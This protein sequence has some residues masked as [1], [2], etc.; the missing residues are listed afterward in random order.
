MMGLPDG[1][2]SFRI[3]LVVLIQYRLWQTA[4]QPPNHV[5]VAITLNAKASS[6]KN[7]SVWM[8]EDYAAR[9]SAGIYLTD[10]RACDIPGT[11]VVLGCRSWSR[12]P[13]SS[14]APSWTSGRRVATPPWRRTILYRSAARHN[15]KAAYYRI[16][17]RNVRIS[18]AVND[19]RHIRYDYVTDRFIPV[20][21]ILVLVLA[22]PVLSYPVQRYFSTLNISECP[23]SY[24]LRRH[25]SLTRIKLTQQS[26][27]C[28]YLYVSYWMSSEPG[29]RQCRCGSTTLVLPSLARTPA[30]RRARTVNK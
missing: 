6:L 4:T 14:V 29:I 2:K 10:A 3:G 15:C 16:R 25:L 30:A 7:Q 8:G 20:M 13:A 19:P 22:C 9:T 18:V 24:Y 5:A 17:S 1:P 23:S 21:L 12:R 27:C 11:E 26:S 28:H